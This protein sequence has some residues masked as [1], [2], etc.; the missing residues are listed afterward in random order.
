MLSWIEHGTWSGSPGPTRTGDLRIRSP[1]WGIFRKFTKVD[2]FSETCMAIGCDQDR[3]F[4]H[5][6]NEMPFLPPIYPQIDPKIFG[7]FSSVLK[8]IS[9]PQ[10]A[11][12]AR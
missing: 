9:I 5:L 10:A 1:F 8:N 6:I 7:A 11:R 4:A 2:N 12:K 3:Q